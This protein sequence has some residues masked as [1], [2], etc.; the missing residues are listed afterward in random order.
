MKY[1]YRLSCPDCTDIDPQGCFDGGTHT[2]EEIF[3]TPEEASEAGYKAT[4]HNIYKFEVVDEKGVVMSPEMIGE[5]NVGMY[6]VES[7]NMV[8]RKNLPRAFDKMLLE[9]SEEAFRLTPELISEIQNV[10]RK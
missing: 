6:Q 7:A 4:S 3:D 2:S 1:R 9:L 8:E 5:M 10:N